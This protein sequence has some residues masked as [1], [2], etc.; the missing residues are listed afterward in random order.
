M[1][2]GAWKQALFFLFIFIKKVRMDWKEVW[3]NFK[4]NS[5][6]ELKYG[7]TVARRLYELDKRYDGQSAPQ[8]ARLAYDLLL[9][10][11]DGDVPLWIQEDF[12]KDLN[13][14][15]DYILENLQSHNW[16]GMA[17]DIEKRF[18]SSGKL[19]IEPYEREDIES[20]TPVVFLFPDPELWDELFPDGE[21]SDEKSEAFKDLEKIVEFYG[22]FISQ[23]KQS[24]F[25]HRIWLEPRYPESAYDYVHQE[26]GG[27]GYTIVP[28]TNTAGVDKAGLRCKTGNSREIEKIK[29]DLHGK[30]KHQEADRVKTYREFPERIYFSAWEEDFDILDQLQDVCD[31]LGRKW[32][33]VAVYRINFNKLH[34]PIY[35]D[36]A[37]KS[38]HA[39]FIYHNVPTQLLQKVYDGSAK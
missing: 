9:E 4:L 18:R 6:E 33:D 36:P 28:K 3:E 30:G 22:Y 1:R 25:F 10:H 19:E 16:K 23:V 38:S 20:L 27:W 8:R 13:F 39:F 31:E 11:F 21:D 26:C 29:A 34:C 37:M 5:P 15:K 14:N 2:L 17:A 35:K 32:E 12:V 7:E 24:W